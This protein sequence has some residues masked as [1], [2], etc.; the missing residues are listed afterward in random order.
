MLQKGDSAIYTTSLGHKYSVL[1]VET[2]ETGEYMV[3]RDGVY[4]DRSYT[5]DFGVYEGRTPILRELKNPYLFT[6]K[7]L[8][9]LE[10]RAPEPGDDE[11]RAI[12]N[13]KLKKYEEEINA[14]WLSYAHIKKEAIVECYEWSSWTGERF[15][16]CTGEVTFVRSDFT[17]YVY[18][19]EGNEHN[20]L[21]SKVRVMK[22]APSVPDGT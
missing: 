4:S 13:L 9:T 2:L 8:A 18:D 7:G 3:L 19:A 22:D 12:W 15:L 21:L 17:C 1:I 5:P 14:K 20:S 10:F 6:G 11:K 16:K